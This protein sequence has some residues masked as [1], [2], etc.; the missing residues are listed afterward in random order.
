MAKIAFIRE[1]LDLAIVPPSP[2]ADRTY[3]GPVLERFEPVTCEFLK[4]VCLGASP[5]TCE[6]DPIPSSLLCDCIDDLLPYLTHVIN[7]SLISG[8]FPDVFKPAI[9]R[10]LIKKISLDKNTLKNFR[11]VS[12]LSFLS[13]ITEKNCS[14]TTSH[15]P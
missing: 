4:K 3:C 5:K 6:L 2:V 12:N 8:S 1:K 11:P 10:P 9:V 7:D 13:K 14:L 15:S